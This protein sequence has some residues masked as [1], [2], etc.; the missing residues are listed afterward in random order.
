MGADMS[1][2]TRERQ[3][4]EVDGEWFVDTPGLSEFTEERQREASVEIMSA[5]CER[6]WFQIFH[7]ITLDAGRLRPDDL[8]TIRMITASCGSF[9]SFLFTVVVNKWDP[10]GVEDPDELQRKNTQVLKE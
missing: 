2:V 7:V 3:E 1:G 8:A 4:E 6:G 5:L 9:D 10:V